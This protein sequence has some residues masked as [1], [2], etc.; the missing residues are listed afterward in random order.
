M[1]YHIIFAR[2]SRRDDK[3]KQF[4]IHFLFIFLTLYIYEN[5]STNHIL[6]I[7]IL[8]ITM[9]EKLKIIILQSCLNNCLKH[10]IFLDTK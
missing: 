9:F 10:S 8:K 6:V 1:S 7:C 2:E 5:Q 3:L 4:G